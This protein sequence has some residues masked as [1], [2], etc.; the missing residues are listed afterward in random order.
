MRRRFV[1][2]FEALLIFF[3]LAGNSASPSQITKNQVP[4][5]QLKLIKTFLFNSWS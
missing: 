1:Y 2:L 5:L 3:M 4:R